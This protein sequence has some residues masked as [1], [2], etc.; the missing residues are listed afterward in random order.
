[1]FSAVAV[2]ALGAQVAGGCGD[3][4]IVSAQLIDTST[5]VAFSSSTTNP[6]STSPG[7]SSPRPSGSTAVGVGDASDGTEFTDPDGTYTITLGPDW[8]EAPNRAVKEVE[9]WV[10]ADVKNGFAPNVNVL[11]Q[12]VGDMSLEDYIDLSVRQMTALD[13]I[14]S[15]VIDIGGGDQLGRIEYAGTLGT[16]TNR[17][18]LHFLAL[19]MVADGEAVVAT[20]VTG[21]NEFDKLSAAHEPY[22]RTLRHI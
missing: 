7:P 19:F 18:A 3:G 12:D 21:E 1:M 8:T 6:G 17:R 16:G 15:T 11:T 4:G 13:I 20:L 10:V 14:D 22:L 2:L 9:Q 5:T